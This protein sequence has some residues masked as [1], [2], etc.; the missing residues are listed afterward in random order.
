MGALVGPLGRTPVEQMGVNLGAYWSHPAAFLVSTG[1]V[2]SAVLI[3]LTNR[4]FS[5]AAE[6][7]PKCVD[8]DGWGCYFAAADHL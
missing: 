1:V 2:I 8:W 6:L 5:I 3:M 4:T 7:A